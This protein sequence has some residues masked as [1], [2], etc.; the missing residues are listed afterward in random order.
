MGYP[1]AELSTLGEAFSYYLE[2]NTVSPTLSQQL[3]AGDTVLVQVNE[4]PLRKQ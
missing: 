2:A 1:L 4:L 3:A